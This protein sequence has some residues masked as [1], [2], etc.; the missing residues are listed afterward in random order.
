MQ[1]F[2]TGGS[3]FVG[4]SLCHALLTQGFGVTVLS[5]SSKGAQRLPKGAG[6]CLG[7]PTEPGSWQG[8]AAAHDHFVNLAGA[9]IFG[10]WNPEYKDLIL[11]T[12]IATTKNLVEAMSRR[13]SAEPAVLVSASAVGYY[14]FRNDEELDESSPPGEDFLARVCREWEAEAEKA[15]QAGARVVRTRFGIVLGQGGALGQML[16]VFK[17]G[18]GGPLGSGRQWFSWVH[19]KD[20]TRAIIFCLEEAGLKGPVNCTAPHPL[21]NKEFSKELGRVLGRPAFLPSPGFAVRMLLGEFG[22][23][24]LEGQ[25]VLPRVLMDAGFEFRFPF[26]REALADLLTT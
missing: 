13:Q 24:L 18:L 26:A 10:R 8:E 20:L 9:S 5:R 1:V 14:G 16:P 7:D 4:A 6:F 25:R 19:H 23:V 17:R 15:A 21:T 22:S 2:I 3:G 12:R 11:K